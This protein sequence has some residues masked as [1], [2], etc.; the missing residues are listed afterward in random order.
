MKVDRRRTPLLLLLLANT[1]VCG[2]TP[3]DA[4]ELTK[5]GPLQAAAID[6]GTT[7]PVGTEHAPV[8]GKDGMPHSGPWIETE[9]AR[10]NQKL[11]DVAGEED[12]NLPQKQDKPTV[13]LPKSNDGVMDDPNRKAPTEGTRGTEGG[14]SQRTKDGKV[15]G[16]EPEQPKE[17]PPVPHSEKEKMG[18]GGF[19]TITDDSSEEAVP[20]AKTPQKFDASSH[21]RAGISTLTYCRSQQIYLHGR[22]IS[23]TPRTHHHQKIIQ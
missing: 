17:V 15:V 2:S 23:P 4:N 1:V 7:G 10:K 13:Q 8:D 21:P 3:S 20:G 11:K 9:T 19:E 18:K 5:R 14:V 6:K 12:A 22:T 16:K